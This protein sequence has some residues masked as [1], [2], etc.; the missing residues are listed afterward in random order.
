MNI[1]TPQPRVFAVVGGDMRLVCLARLLARDR[2]RVYTYASESREHADDGGVVEVVGPTAFPKGCVV[3]LPLPAEDGEYLS[4]PLSSV[5]LTAA[6]LF[7]ALEPGTLVCAGK[8]S[9]KLKDAAADRGLVLVDYFDREELTVMNAVATAEA[10]VAL[11]ATELP[12]TLH[13]S[14]ALVVGFGRIGKLLALAL[15]GLGCRVSASARKFGDLAWVKALGATPVQ[16]A[17]LDEVIQDYDVIFNTVP[18]QVLG[19]RA[20]ERVRKGAPIIDLASAPGG[21]DRAAADA[22]G[23]KVIHALGLPGKV[24]PMTA[25]EIIRDSIYN[26]LGDGGM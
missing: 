22:L 2:H 5:K 21:V 16:T 6:E 23:V 8:A 25:G 10:A 14:R 26:I 13:S 19:R 20:L 9:E 15:R 17:R 7:D 4:A 12:M 3:V 24:S 1:V 11:A 18:A